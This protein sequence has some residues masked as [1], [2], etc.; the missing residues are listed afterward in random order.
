MI[1]VAKFYHFQPSEI[2]ELYLD[3]LEMW[4]NGIMW[5]NKK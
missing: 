5:L 1:L 2:D 3:E 4:L